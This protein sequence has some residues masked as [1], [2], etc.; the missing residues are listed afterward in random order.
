MTLN[1]TKRLIMGFAERRQA[2]FTVDE[3]FGE[4]K[5]IKDKQRLSSCASD[6]FFDRKL[7]RKRIDGRTFSYVHPAFATGDYK[8]Y[9]DGQLPEN[10][11]QSE[12]NEIKNAERIGEIEYGP[13]E[14]ENDRAASSQT[15]EFVPEIEQQKEILD[16]SE[17][18]NDADELN[19]YVNRINGSIPEDEELTGKHQIDIESYGAAS[20]MKINLPLNSRFTLNAPHGMS[21]T[22]EPMGK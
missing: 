18:D 14:R 2:P 1:D 8:N 21:I 9:L 17:P 16:E 6:L 22:I 5:D 15:E 13:V 19:D 3:A 10:H 4:I 11:K 7:A 20:H 12:E